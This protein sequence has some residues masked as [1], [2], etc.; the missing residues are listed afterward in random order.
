MTVASSQVYVNEA[1]DTATA[2]AAHLIGT[3]KYQTFIPLDDS[4]HLQQTV[5]TYNWWIPAQSVG[6]SKLYGDIYNASGSN[7]IIEVR[8]VWPIPRSDIAV[9]PTVAV[10]IGIYRTS[11]VGSGGSAFTYN[12]GSSASSH[13]I[14]PWDTVNATLPAQITARS[15][16]TGGAAISALWWPNYV[17]TE[18]LNAATYMSALTNLLPVGTMNQ[19][20]T[21]NQGQGM[22]IKQGTVAS[23]GSIGFLVLFTVIG[24]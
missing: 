22:L 6:A 2:V 18:E 1:P 13:V 21:L 19:R 14:T 10:E 8:G 15:A 11:T 23:V 24:P 16:P 9:A 12:G 4:G 3:K 5:P 20:L 17:L 7:R